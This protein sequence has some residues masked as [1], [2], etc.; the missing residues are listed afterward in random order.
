MIKPEKYLR[1]KS[2]DAEIYCEL[3]GTKNTKTLVLLH[4]NGEDLH[5]FDK[6]IEFFSKSFKVI[7]VDSRGH[8]KSTRGTALLDFYTMAKDILTVLDSLGIEKAHLLGFSDGA[9]A[10]LHLA[11]I[12][13]ERISSMI[14]LG[15]N[16]RPDGILL[17]YRLS[18]LL[19]Y[20][21]LSFLSL[22]SDKYRKQK[23]IWGLMVHHPNLTLE[24]IE[25]IRIPSLII[26]GQNDMVSQKQN[27]EISKSI[28]G[29]KRIT[30]ENADH[31]L[32]YK[33]SDVF[34][35]IANNF[36]DNLNED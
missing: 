8:G 36:L 2:E 18:I 35:K 26:T 3:Y 7:A 30:I 17:K 24:E 25:H 16:Y 22:F 28:A 23:E 15:A 20:I 1:V 27:D 6:Q 14:L 32:S 5:Y 4:G 9:I 33:I 10:A 34:N 29:S 11:L 13:P 12:A 19:N 31:F 21:R